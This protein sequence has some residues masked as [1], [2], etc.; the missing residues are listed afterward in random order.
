VANTCLE[1]GFTGTGPRDM[2]RGHSAFCRVQLTKGCDDENASGRSNSRHLA[3]C[4]VLLE[5]VTQT[6]IQLAVIIAP[7]IVTIYIPSN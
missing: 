7:V 6:Q 5:E 1:K 3:Q 4:A 2:G